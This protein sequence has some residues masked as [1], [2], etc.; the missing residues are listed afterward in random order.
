MSFDIGTS[1]GGRGCFDDSISSS[2]AA[3]R[4][5]YV[6]TKDALVGLR[7]LVAAVDPNVTGMAATSTLSSFLPDTGHA[8]HQR[9][10]GIAIFMLIVQNCVLQR[11]DEDIADLEQ[12]A[13]DFS[14]EVF[15]IAK[16]AQCYR[17]LGASYALLCLMA[18]YMGT[19][20]AVTRTEILALYTDYRRDFPGEQSADKDEIEIRKIYNQLRFGLVG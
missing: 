2:L 11:Y 19:N 8:Y 13:C 1:S 6:A 16:K 7:G 18:A 14:I 4:A 20:D 5:A 15:D 9:N 17:P 10:L 3:V 12:D